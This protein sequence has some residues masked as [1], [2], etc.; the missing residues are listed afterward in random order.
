MRP[1]TDLSRRRSRRSRGRLGLVAVVGVLLVVLFSL[2]GIA[3]F[4]TDYLWFGEVHLTSVWRQVLGAKV[5]LALLFSAL[6]FVVLWGNLLI[7]ERIA[8]AFRPAGPEEDMVERYHQ[9]VGERAGLVRLG[10]AA[11]FTLIAGPGVQSQWRA[12][13]LFRN[14]VPWGQVDPQFHKDIGFFVFKLPF[15]KFLVD[16]AFTTIVIV[17][18]VTVVAHYLNGGIRL[19]TPA[20]MQRVTGQVKVHLSVLLGVLALLKAVGYWLQ[21][22]QLDF[23][24]RGVVTGATYTD[25]KAQ[26]PALKLLLAISIFAAV[27]FLV[28][29]RQR[30]WVL[31]VLAVGLW[32]M[33][34]VVVGAAYPA[35][36]QN[37]RVK[38]NEASKERPYIARNI[39]ATR[40]ALNLGGT[41]VNDFQYST[42]LSPQ[43]LLDNSETIRN[44]RLWDRDNIEKSYRQLQSFR[45]FFEFNDASVDRYDI[46]GRRTQVWLSGRELRPSQVP[47]SWVNRHL[48]FTHG[49][50]AV[51]AP[52]NA[53]TADGDPQPVVKDLPPQSAPGAPEIK[54]PALYFGKGLPGYGIIGTDQQETDY[55]QEGG[56]DHTSRYHGLGGVKIGSLV[57]RAAFA[58][59]FGDINPLISGSISGRSKV[60]YIRDIRDRVRK[61]APF[62]LYDSDPYLAVLDGHLRWIQDAYTTTSRYPYGQSADVSRLPPGADLRAG[63]NYARNS[64]KIVIDAYDGTMRFYA[65][66]TSDPLL[67]AWRKAFP[68]LFTDV[69]MIDKLDP[70]L[71][72][73]VRYPED[74]FRV[75]TNMYGLYHM[76]QPTEFYKKT[77]KWDIAQDP[78]SGPVSA[79]TPSV[80]FTPGVAGPTGQARMDPYYLLMRLPNEPSESFLILQPFVPTSAD[81]SRK[82]LTAFM[83][84]KSDPGDYGKIETFVMPRDLQVD[85]PGQINSRINQDPSFSPQITLLNSSG[86]SVIQGNLLV[87][88]VNHSLL[89]VRPYFV[90]ATANDLPQLK[91]VAVVFAGRVKVANS[92]K[93][94]LDALFGGGAVTQEQ[95]KPATS[96][97]PGVPTPTTTP[98]AQTGTSPSQP[99]L[100]QAQAALDDAQKALTAGDLG[101]YQADVDK[102][103]RLIQQANQ[104]TSTTSPATST[105]TTV[106][107]AST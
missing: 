3:G 22:Y 32:A 98:P 68:K 25:V 37:F 69:T 6:F 76:T 93:E 53:T 71:R 54:V 2:R 14:H 81:D 92:L 38:P 7:A 70:G 102:A 96:T 9:V 42:N 21:R 57:R 107:A 1:P 66:D 94:A 99:L 95:P 11:L 31:P 85:G 60:L 97:T 35:F 83:V 64:V 41:K 8:P 80:T 77:D 20:P 30:G 91:K 62:L 89:Y 65:W 84:A 101:R 105:T 10:V 28:N 39:D 45:P 106:P 50:G 74:L 61:A 29:I 55:P 59:R 48:V 51:L 103:R 104:G 79:P 5:V 47:N 15:Y 12:W 82:N 40:A 78:G 23:S 90:T 58:L 46:S 36:I 13:L 43:D 49:F 19:Q 86:S 27:L 73:H 34:A 17:L 24:T 67:R 75:Q 4:Y 100:D 52:A 44:V 18:I 72:Q 56:G 63:F 26:L 16:W 87:I 33:V 88:P